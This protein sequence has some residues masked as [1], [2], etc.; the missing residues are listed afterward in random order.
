MFPSELSIK[1]ENAPT[2]YFH[3]FL[4]YFIFGWVA[5][6]KNKV[7]EYVNCPYKFAYRAGVMALSWFLTKLESL[8]TQHEESCPLSLF[9]SHCF[10]MLYRYVKLHEDILCVWGTMMR[11]HIFVNNR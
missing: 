2:C 7:N 11:T 6:A 3:A 10:D 5:R 9:A 8:T 1:S 4:V